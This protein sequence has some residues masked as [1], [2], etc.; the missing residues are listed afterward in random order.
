MK[1]STFL[2]LVAILLFTN[3]EK[4]KPEPD[5]DPD[6]DPIEEPT[7]PYHRFDGAVYEN[8]NS[9]VLAADGNLLLC[10][11]TYYNGPIAQHKAFDIRKVADSE[12]I[13]SIWTT[14]YLT[15]YDLDATA[16]VE[17]PNGDVF[18]CGG[19]N[20]FL[21]K[22]NSFGEVQWKKVYSAGRTAKN[23]IYTSDSNLLIAT[24]TESFDFDGAIVAVHLLKVTTDG[25]V[26]WTKTYTNGVKAPTHLLET[27]HGEYVLTGSYK[28]ISDDYMLKVSSEGEVIWEKK[29]Q[30]SFKC[31]HSA[32]E[33]DN[34]DLLVTG[35]MVTSQGGDENII[36]FRID[37]DGNVVWFKNYGELGVNEV[38]R[39]IRRNN[40][41]TF[42]IA[43]FT[44]TDTDRLILVKVD[45][46]GNQ[47]WYKRLGVVNNNESVYNL[48]KDTNDDNIIV[49]GYDLNFAG[50]YKKTFVVRTDG[51]GN[52]K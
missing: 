2:F 24:Q 18:V 48:L 33:L 49:G 37:R 21:I 14:P 52:L 17:T 47:I 6:P 29:I 11:N 35:K 31:F 12:V 15:G 26:I 22:L 46:N 43:G 8:D 36:L 39:S 16:I 42:T 4:D 27:H 9:A 1:P 20:P 38:G 51:E 25:E 28:D 41:G 13:N 32:I 40:D 34:G 50:Y 3:C 30:V 10:M 19:S 23:I 44:N 45:E 7:L 5:P